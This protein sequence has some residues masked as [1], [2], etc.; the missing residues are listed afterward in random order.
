MARGL[1]QGEEKWELCFLPMYRC[2]KRPSPGEEKGATCGTLGFRFW[3]VCHYPHGRAV[4]PGTPGGD[5][6]LGM[7]KMDWNSELMK[8]FVLEGLPRWLRG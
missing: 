8:P 3:K 1:H 6:C 2:P 7:K 4:G 5:M